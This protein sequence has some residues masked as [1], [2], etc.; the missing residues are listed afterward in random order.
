MYLEQRHNVHRLRRCLWLYRT[1]REHNQQQVFEHQP[2]WRDSQSV[3]TRIG[4]WESSHE[5]WYCLLLGHDRRIR[6]DVHH[7]GQL[8]FGANDQQHISCK[9]DN[10]QQ[11][12]LAAPNHLQSRI[13]LLALL[14]S[15]ASQ[16]SL[17]LA[18]RCAKQSP[19]RLCAGM[20]CADGRGHKN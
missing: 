12:V 8:P 9:R 6:R 11:L 20:V 3:Q 14:P 2:D 7:P 4:H 18:G 17:N 5:L 19:K 10:E 13:H 15:C 16:K 1:R